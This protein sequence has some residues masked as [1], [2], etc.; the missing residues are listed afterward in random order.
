MPY[1]QVNMSRQTISQ[2]TEKPLAELNRNQEI[3][4][5]IP[6]SQKINLRDRQTDR[7][8][9]LHNLLIINQ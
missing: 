6:V 3:N 4:N 2:Y 9:P 8:K 7:Q 5:L 1:H